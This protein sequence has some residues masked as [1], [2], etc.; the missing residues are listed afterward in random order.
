MCVVFKCCVCGT[1]VHVHVYM[2]LWVQRP[3]EDIG[4]P[5]LTLLMYLFVCLLFIYSLLLNLELGWKTASLKNPLVSIL[6]NWSY[7]HGATMSGYFHRH[8]NLN[9]D[10]YA[11]IASSHIPWA[12]TFFSPFEIWS[13]C[14]AQGSFDF[15]IFLPPP[16]SHAP[17]LN[18][19]WGCIFWK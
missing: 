7:R 2:P 5:P 19:L 13:F 12:I 9:S 11:C 3:E 14:A 15:M 6:Q 10:P 17:V 8:G 4:W 16:P 18:R 1:W